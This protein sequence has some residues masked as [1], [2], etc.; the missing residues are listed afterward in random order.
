[1]CFNVSFLIIILIPL[2]YSLDDSVSCVYIIY[3]PKHSVYK[4]KVTNM[5]T[6]IYCR[7]NNLY[8]TVDMTP[9]TVL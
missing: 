7:H 4:F 2:R 9:N 5:T 3:H 6:N 8:T 1:M